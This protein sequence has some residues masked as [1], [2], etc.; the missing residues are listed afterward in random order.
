MKR[1][2]HRPLRRLP[3]LAF[4]ALAACGGGSDDDGGAANL[5]PTVSLAAP[6]TALTGVAVT[7]TATAADPDDSVAKVEFFDGATLLG[8]DTSSPYAL[9]WTPATA[10]RARPHRA[11]HRFARRGDDERGG[12]RAGERPGGFDTTA[13]TA[14]LTAPPNLASGLT[15]TIALAVTRPTTSAWRASSSRS[16]AC[17]SA[18]TPTAPYAATVDASLFTTGQHVLRARASDAAGN[19]SPWSTALVQFGGNV[20]Q[21]AGFTRNETWVTGLSNATAF[22]QAA[23]GRIFVASRAARSASSRTAC[24][25]RRRSRP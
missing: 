5:P 11:R 24:S 17:R 2:L 13:P 20:D 16:T 4:L 21:P 18:R 14:T 15:G 1:T 7:L 6:A 10:G 8:T 3:G 12:E 19:V 22:A 25:C 9:N 23:D